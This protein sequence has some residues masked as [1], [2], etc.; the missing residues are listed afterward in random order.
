[1]VETFL[2]IIDQLS[3]KY[4]VNPIIPERATF[5]FILESPHIQEL[6]HSA[7]VAGSSGKTMASVLLDRAVEKPLGILVKENVAAGFP[8]KWLNPIGIVNVSN[9][10]L[11]KKA[12]DIHDVERY[13]RFFHLLEK[14][15]TSNERIVY[16]SQEMNDLQRAILERFDEQ[17]KRLIGRKCTLVPCGRFAQKFLRLSGIKADEWTIISDVPHPSYNSWNQTR[18][19]QKIAELKQAF[20]KSKTQQK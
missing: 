18:Y 3:E 6:K 2:K 1:M 9:I 15:R 10:P 13:E 11:Q 8:D 19:K 4:S 20:T 16:T 5:I 14:L 7:P 17:L 12:Y